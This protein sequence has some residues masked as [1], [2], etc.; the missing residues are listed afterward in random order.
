MRA[1]SSVSS[2]L[3]EE[4]LRAGMP[5]VMFNNIAFDAQYGHAWFSYR[6]DGRQAV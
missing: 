5:V 6:I 3:A 1:S 4:C 2:A